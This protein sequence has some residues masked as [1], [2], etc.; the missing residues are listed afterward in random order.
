M[1][2]KFLNLK[3][4]ENF[5]LKISNY[6]SGFTLIEILVVT[7]II[8][9]LAGLVFTNIKIISR[10]RD[11]QRKA[12]LK[13]IAAALEQ[14]RSDNGSYPLS[15]ANYK[16]QA[17]CNSAALGN[18]DCTIIYL[19]KIPKDPN[20]TAWAWGG[21]YYYYSDGE[22]YMLVA[23]IENTQDPEGKTVIIFKNICT[24]QRVYLVTSP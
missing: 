1:K 15:T 4:N 10:A 14:Y 11:A 23:C 16:L 13:K 17:N 12:D 7:A 3:F 22:Y 18:D 2:T 20:G 5:K 19:N 6:R 8:S 24:T 21:D 9:V